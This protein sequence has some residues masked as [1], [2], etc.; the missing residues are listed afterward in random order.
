MSALLIY[1]FAGNFRAPSPDCFVL[2]EKQL[3]PSRLILTACI[4]YHYQ[5]YPNRYNK[6]KIIENCTLFQTI[7]FFNAKSLKNLTKVD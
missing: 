4:S 7:E 5:N 2:G 1:Q 6:D 3:L